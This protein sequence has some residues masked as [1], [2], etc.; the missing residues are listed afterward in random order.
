MQISL[1]ETLLQHGFYIAQ[2]ATY[3]LQLY[4]FKQ[5][6]HRKVDSERQHP[7]T[8]IYFFQDIAFEICSLW[9]LKN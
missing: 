3:E 2:K 1:T 8:F 4:P 5:S 6:D 9:N 7:T